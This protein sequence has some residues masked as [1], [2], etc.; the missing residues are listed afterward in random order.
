VTLHVGL[1]EATNMSGLQPLEQEIF[2][3]SSRPGLPLCRAFGP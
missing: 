3:L 1:D 2:L